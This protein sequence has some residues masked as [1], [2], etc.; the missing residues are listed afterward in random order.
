MIDILNRLLTLIYRFLA[1]QRIYWIAWKNGYKITKFEWL[2]DGDTDRIVRITPT[3]DGFDHQGD[4]C[5][6]QPVRTA[7][8]DNDGGE[9]TLIQHREM[10]VN[11]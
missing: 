7:Q 10:N 2:P 6:C 3:G 4:D 11:V 9:Y 8:P 5:P 1:K